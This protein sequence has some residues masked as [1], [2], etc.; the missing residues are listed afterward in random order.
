[1]AMSLI[2]KLNELNVNVP[3]D[4]SVIG[5]DDIEYVKYFNPPLTTISQPKEELGIKAVKSIIDM[6]QNKSIEQTSFQIH[7][8]LIIR[9]SVS[10]Q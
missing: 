5:Y 8:K 6:I 7:P 3:K 2:S 10:K 4:M 1:M 9:K